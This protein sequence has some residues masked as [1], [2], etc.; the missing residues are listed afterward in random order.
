MNGVGLQV[1]K[2]HGNPQ[3]PLAFNRSAVQAWAKETAQC[4][5]DAGFDGVVQVINI[6]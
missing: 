3:N 4:V 6:K 5:A 2:K 1:R